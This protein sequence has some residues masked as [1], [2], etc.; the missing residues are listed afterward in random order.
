MTAVKHTEMG[1]EGKASRKHT[2]Q[3]KHKRDGLVPVLILAQRDEE[4]L[5][6]I[7]LLLFTR[8]SQACRS[9]VSVK[10]QV[11]GARQDT[12]HG[13][14]NA[15]HPGLADLDL[16]QLHQPTAEGG[17]AALLEDDQLCGGR[18]VRGEGSRWCVDK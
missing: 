14:T 10:C 2:T 6:Q 7:V 3:L 11:K 1:R 15:T 9:S 4:V 8:V 12:E 17:H 5:P 16:G 13:G 18:G